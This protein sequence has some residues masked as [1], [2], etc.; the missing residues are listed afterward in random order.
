MC[1]RGFSRVHPALQPRAS[2]VSSLCYTHDGAMLISAGRDHRVRLWEA[3][4]GLNTLTHFAGARN[5]AS[6]CKQLGVC[7]ERGTQA[8][9]PVPPH[10]HAHHAPPC[11]RA[12]RSAL[13]T[14]V[15]THQARACVQAAR[16]YFPTGE[17]LVEY[18]LS[19]GRRLRVLK[20]HFGATTCC[21]ADPHAPRVF[22]GGEDG[23]LNAWTPPPCGLRRPA[24]AEPFEVRPFG[25]R[26]ALE[27]PAERGG[28]SG[29]E[30]AALGGYGLVA[31]RGGTA[32]VQAPAY[33]G[34]E[35]TAL[36]GEGGRATGRLSAI[37]AASAAAI[38]PVRDAAQP[39]H[40][41]SS[42]ARPA[43][44]VEDV[45]AWSD[46]EEYAA[47]PAASAERRRGRG[48]RAGPGAGGGARAGGDALA[49]KRRRQ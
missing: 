35:A 15:C 21:A 33:R 44:A 46:D 20:G 38:E 37:N 31:A 16:L 13:C 4:S 5:S 23:A 10:M 32:C 26:P 48:Q 36:S 40:A 24:P 9:H 17:G 6:A 19:S 2:Q 30:A 41:S 18:E 22:S 29:H 8:T 49:H 11:A 3:E 28:G 34:L 25:K 39:P 1:T 45:D 42:S 43:V 14:H 12:P 47:P 27:P 7:A